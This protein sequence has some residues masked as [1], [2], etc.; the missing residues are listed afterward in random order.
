MNKKLLPFIVTIGG[1]FL[2]GFFGSRFFSSTQSVQFTQLKP[3]TTTSEPMIQREKPAT[4]SETTAPTLTPLTPAT[5]TN[6][7]LG[8]ETSKAPSVS[9]IQFES[10]DETPDTTD[11]VT[12]EVELDDE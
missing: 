5:T 11:S 12:I 1:V 10:E 2:F 4:S 9:K 7:T 6:K 8:D 3:E